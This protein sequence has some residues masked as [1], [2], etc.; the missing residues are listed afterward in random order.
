MGAAA[1]VTPVNIT[2]A[3]TGLSGLA[4]DPESRRHTNRGGGE[5]FVDMGCKREA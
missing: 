1:A 5:G 3:M 2:I 4:H